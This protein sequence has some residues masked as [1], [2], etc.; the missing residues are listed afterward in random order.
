MNTENITVAAPVFERLAYNRKELQTLLG[1]SETT[2]WRLE[3]QG[4][5]QPVK[6][7]R[8]RLYTKKAVERFLAGGVTQ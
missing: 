7:L 6:G 4:L 3:K 1:I 8:T 2:V 5:L